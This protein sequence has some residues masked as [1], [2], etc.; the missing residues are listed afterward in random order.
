MLVRCAL[1][2]VCLPRASSLIVEVVIVTHTILITFLD[3]VHF[4]SGY[5]KGGG[6]GCFNHVFAMS[7]FVTDALTKT[8]SAR[9]IDYRLQSSMSF[10]LCF[11]CQGF[12][13]AMFR[14]LMLSPLSR[15]IG[16]ALFSSDYQSSRTFEHRDDPL[17]VMG[18]LNRVSGGQFPRVPK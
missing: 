8:N 6:I 16:C 3:D 15:N 12:Q 17:L 4:H 14:S 9:S 2:S 10:F 7:T 1:L 5:L 18:R 11:R 13:P